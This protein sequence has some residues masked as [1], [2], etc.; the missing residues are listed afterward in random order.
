MDARDIIA[1]A[2]TKLAR[3]LV[4][5]SSPIMAL[6]PFP[7]EGLNTFGV[8]ADSRM[9][10]D[11]LRALEWGVEYST[12]VVFHESLHVNGDH[13]GRQGSREHELWNWAC[14]I[15]INQIVRDAGYNWPPRAK[16]LMPETFGFDPNLSPEE[17][18]ELL[19][20]NP[21]AKQAAAAM[22]AASASTTGQSRNFPGCGTP[23]G[24][25]AGNKQGWEEKAD[26]LSGVEGQSRADAKVM[27]RATALKIKEHA[28]Q[29]AARRR[30]GRG[31]GTVPAGL[32]AWAT[33]E[34]RPP[35]VPWQ[36][37]LAA[38]VRTALAS[39]SGCDD[40]T[41]SRVSRRY[42]GMKRAWGVA[43]PVM[44]ALRSP[45]PEVAL[46]I[47]TSGSML[48]KP[49]EQAMSEA[50]A[51][52]KAIGMPLKAYA[53]DAAVQAVAR[54]VGARDIE[55][56]NAGGGGTDMVVGI[57][58]AAKDRPDVI[59]LLTDGGTPWPAEDKMPPC[60]LVVAVLGK[61][62]VPAHIRKVVRV[63]VEVEEEV[64]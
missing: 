2:R 32:E 5:F 50:V 40:Y 51:V 20:S 12:T 23:C 30:G 28:R 49:L 13:F 63:P 41:R 52:V 11:P 22:A 19:N 36:R 4:Y 47:D 42:W 3:N 9:A 46:V 16:P 25:G 35:E 59:V 31:Q 29:V 6:R 60:K 55:K 38:D 10:F 24:T 58:A 44:P 26:K 1:A 53:V 64:V 62:R 39:K 27:R 48:G 37:V 21:A 57:E 61:A 18:Y 8:D 34:L 45:R 33:L 7:L 56:L 43:C 15:A 54:V 17:Y 14:D